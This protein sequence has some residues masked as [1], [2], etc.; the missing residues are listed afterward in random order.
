MTARSEL[1]FVVVAWVVVGCGS[2][3]KRPTDEE[4]EARALAKDIA[5][6]SSPDVSARASGAVGVANLCCTFERDEWRP[7]L[8]RMRPR[9]CAA[10]EGALVS[11]RD[12]RV[13]SKLLI[14][15]NDACDVTISARVV[16]DLCGETSP[17]EVIN[18]AALWLTSIEPS[19]EVATAILK[20][21][22]GLAPEEA[23]RP[24]LLIALGSFG[25]RDLVPVVDAM[26]DPDPR[27][28]DIG[29]QALSFALSRGPLDSPEA[30]RAL[31]RLTKDPDRRLA[32]YAEVIAKNYRDRLLETPDA[33][34]DRYLADGLS[35]EEV[36]MLAVRQF[37]CKAK[38][39]RTVLERLARGEEGT[40]GL[41]VAAKRALGIRAKRCHN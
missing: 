8:P 7:A 12:P 27:V 34:V 15:S 18:R 6:L 26:S 22:K 16:V 13:L 41:S 2:E 29:V 3:D 40:P 10:L 14:A 36:R 39:A 1:A 21:V 30:L 19:Q 35:F 28:R 17:L 33:T 4:L 9:A 38:S 24:R 23:P 32:S 37:F 11:E 25:E 20:R 31:D 5:A